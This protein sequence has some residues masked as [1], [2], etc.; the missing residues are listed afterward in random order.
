MTFIVLIAA[1]VT[2]LSSLRKVPSLY[3]EIFL[4]PKQAVC[5]KS[6]YLQNDVMCVLPTGY[7]KSLVFH[8]LPM[9]L[10]ARGR[11]CKRDKKMSLPLL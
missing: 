1:V 5:I 10:F 2:L 8:L 4:K 3:D 6:I 9:L 7:G 11:I